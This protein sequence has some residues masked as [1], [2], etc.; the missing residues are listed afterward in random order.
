[1]KCNEN[2]KNCNPIRRT[3]RLIFFEFAYSSIWLF[4]LA[5]VSNRASR[6]IIFSRCTF[7]EHGT[8]SR[9]YLI[10]RCASKDQFMLFDLFKAY[11]Y[12]ETSYKLDIFIRKDLF[13]YFLLCVYHFVSNCTW[14]LTLSGM[15]GMKQVII[16]TIPNTR[17]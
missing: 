15:S 16:P 3:L 4:P 11:G 12:I 14:I 8:Y 9:W 1:M 5:S 7:I 13:F 10:N 17:C 6:A 2:N